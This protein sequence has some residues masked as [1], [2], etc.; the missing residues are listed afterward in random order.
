[1]STAI[2]ELEEHYGTAFLDRIGKRLHLTEAGRQMKSYA[3]HVLSLLDEMEGQAQDWEESGTLRVGSSITAG[4]VLLPQLI[5]RLNE[6]YPKLRVEV[7]I[8]NSDVVEQGVLSNRMDIGFIEGAC[9][10]GEM[11]EYP[12]RGD[13]LVFLCPPGHPFEGKTISLRDLEQAPFLF[14]ERGSAGRELVESALKANGVNVSPLWQSIST[15]SL[16]SAVAAGLGVAALPLP[17]VQRSVELGEVSLFAVEGL[18][19]GREYRLIHHK[20]K[21][22]TRPMK[23]MMK[24]VAQSGLSSSDLH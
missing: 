18:R 14:R 3:Q 23:A 5:R 13:E 17:L 8:C 7:D 21:Y 15:Q 10:R 24:L 12:F 9:R 1:M 16:I 20:N 6:A 11:A 4:T 2:R 19:L 22:L